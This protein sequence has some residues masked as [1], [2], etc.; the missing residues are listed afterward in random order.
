MV[1]L[2][3]E[4]SM[5][6]CNVWNRV[7]QPI[8]IGRTSSLFNLLSLFLSAYGHEEGRHVPCAKYRCMWMLQFELVVNKPQRNA[9]AEVCQTLISILKV[10][11][12]DAL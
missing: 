5:L 11:L 2:R 1:T 7:F 9:F 6:A 3:V 12:K 4:L 8:T 10:H